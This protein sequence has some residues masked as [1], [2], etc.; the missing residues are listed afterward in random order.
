MNCPNCN[1][2]K[3]HKNGKHPATGKQKFRCTQCGKEFNE[4]TGGEAKPKVGMTLDQFRSKHD[5]DY[6]LDK[7]LKSLE[8]DMIYEKSDVLKIANLSPS[9]PGVT[10]VLEAASSY[11]G[12]ISQRM[13]FSHPDTI[14]ELKKHA[15][16]N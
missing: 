14:S 11:Y 9:Y 7:A 15:K 3:V 4:D 2:E 10:A 12:K 1:S 13:Y 16:I 6:I 8:K 5:V